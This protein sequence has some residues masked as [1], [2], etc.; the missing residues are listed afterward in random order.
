MEATCSRV[1]II[2]R[3]SLVCDEPLDELTQ[4]ASLEERFLELTADADP[5]SSR[6]AGR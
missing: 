1:L 4:G 6:E 2:A 5:L 3:G